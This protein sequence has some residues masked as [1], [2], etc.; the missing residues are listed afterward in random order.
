[1]APTKRN[2]LN[3]NRYDRKKVSTNIHEELLVALETQIKGFADIVW[4]SKSKTYNTV[5][6]IKYNLIQI[7]LLEY[8]GHRKKHNM[9]DRYSSFSSKYL[10]VELG[11]QYEKMMSMFFVKTH[12]GQSVS[13]IR[14]NTTLKYKL[15]KEIVEICDKVYLGEYKL[16]GVITRGGKKLNTLPEY[17]IRGRLNGGI[18]A[19]NRKND[20]FKNYVRLNEDNM[21]LMLRMWRDL[22]R[23]RHGNKS[24]K[25]KRWVNILKEVGKDY[26]DISD[27]GSDRRNKHAIEL[28]NN[29]LV[30]IV[31]QGR[32][33][34]LYTEKDSGRLY[35]DEKLNLQTLP[36]EMRYIAMGG[37]NYYEYD[38]E[39][40]H[41]SIIYQL[42]QMWG[43][44]PLD[45]IS[46]Y[47]KD[48]KDTRQ[49]ISIGT[50]VD[51]NI[52]KT[53]LIDI[54]Y[55]AGI[56][57]KHTYDE[58][59]GKSF[60][61]AILN[62]LLE[63]TNDNRDDAIKL[64]DTIAGN[65]RVSAIYNDLES[66]RNFLK[67]KYRIK[68]LRNKDYL[69]NTIGKITSILDYKGEKRSRG[70]MLSHITQGIES[71]ALRV[72]LEE[73]GKYFVMPHHDGWVS[74]KDNN[75][76][77]LEAL[78]R[79]KTAEMMRNYDG[80]DGHFSFTITKKKLND[81]T[82]GDWADKITSSKTIKEMMGV[83]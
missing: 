64:F 41:Y 60:D 13:M 52:I 32:L 55:G 73:E 5:K 8:N 53:I 27:E 15:K 66:A 45:A 61:N 1:M 54:V 47:I 71:A 36:R 33:L 69:E 22:Y 58:K 82:K 37:M 12:P 14:D 44:K 6:D 68:T 74:M 62:T 72:I 35:G 78:V 83:N 3:R 63:Y 29:T 31:G 40:C 59:K 30:D 25:I 48:T 21:V 28:I 79:G 50:G 43:G 9:D 26:R 39:N 2:K 51:Y 81:I 23:N 67:S 16:H 24:I 17:T 65:K 18:V 56:K 4:I 38:I 70:A 20:Q 7:V 42:N 49:L 75:T 76:D 80:T 19:K 11:V 77:I 34:Q 10:Q 46:R 57:Q